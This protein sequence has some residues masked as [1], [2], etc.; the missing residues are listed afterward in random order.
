MEEKKEF[1]Q[2][3]QTQSIDMPPQTQQDFTDETNRLLMK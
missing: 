3:D 2:A 1:G